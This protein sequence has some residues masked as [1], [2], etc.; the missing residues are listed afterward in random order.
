MQPIMKQVNNHLTWVLVAII[1]TIA[2]VLFQDK[3][4]A[5]ASHQIYSVTENHDL[6]PIQTTLHVRTSLCVNYVWACHGGRTTHATWVSQGELMQVWEINLSQHDIGQAVLIKANDR[7]ISDANYVSKTF[8]VT[9][10]TAETVRQ[11]QSAE[12][13]QPSLQPRQAATSNHTINTTVT[14]SNINGAQTTV[15]NATAT[16]RDISIS[17]DENFVRRT[18]NALDVIES[19]PE[20]AYI[21]VST[22]LSYI[23]QCPR[24]YLNPRSG[25]RVNVRTRRFY[26]Y[27][28]T[29]T[30]GRRGWYA[31]VILHEAVHV[32]QYEEHRATS[33]RT[34]FPSTHEAIRSREIEAVEFQVLF[35]DDIGATATADMARRIIQ[36][37]HRG[38]YWW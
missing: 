18:L 17:G 28:Q 13:R 8:N 16:W 29:Y 10:N 24:Q 4:Q 38:I 25:G 31:S 20:W 5:S 2:L 32:R 14:I 34:A 7:L 6:A 37:V 3:V 26:V 9:E 12:P 27:T 33:P 36:D 11:E 30:S 35:L 22:F 23:V 1:F 21:Y 19:G 15:T